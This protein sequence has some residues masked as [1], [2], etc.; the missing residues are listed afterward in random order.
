MNTNRNIRKLVV[1]CVVQVSCWTLLT[2]NKT[3]I[4]KRERER[5]ICFEILIRERK[6]KRRER[7]FNTLW[8]LVLLFNDEVATPIRNEYL[9][10]RGIKFYNRIFCTGFVAIQRERN[11]RA[12]REIEQVIETYQ[13]L[14]PNLSRFIP[15]H[16]PHSFSTASRRYVYRDAVVH[17]CISLIQFSLHSS[18]S[19]FDKVYLSTVK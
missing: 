9:R 14:R 15:V 6:K 10:G 7:F 19:L 12:L 1:E 2:N 8:R 4:F 17:W 13:F 5:E 18:F 16:P 3:R 11:D